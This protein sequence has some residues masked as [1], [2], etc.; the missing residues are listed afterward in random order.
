MVSNDLLRRDVRMLGDLLGTVITEQAGPAALQLVEDVRQRARARRAGT[1]GAEASLVA[2]IVALSETEART[3]A[4]AFSVF[5]DMSN[6]AGL[7]QWLGKT[8]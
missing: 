6:L 3:V 1:P 7:N 4:R 2:R 8:G 5:L